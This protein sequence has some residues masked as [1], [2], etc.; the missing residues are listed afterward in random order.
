MNE[1]SE[2]AGVIGKQ[3]KQG[4]ECENIQNWGRREVEVKANIEMRKL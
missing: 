4:N 2:P 3:G 1:D